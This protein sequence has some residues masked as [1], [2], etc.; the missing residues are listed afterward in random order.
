MEAETEFMR[1]RVKER[2][3][4]R[5]RAAFGGSATLV[6]LISDS[7]LQIRESTRFSH[8]GVSHQV[9]VT[10][11]GSPRKRMQTTRQRSGRHEPPGTRQ[12]S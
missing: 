5:G 12:A 4:R 9:V 10:C 8:V 2:L 1:P 6:T 7:G 3:G 11:F